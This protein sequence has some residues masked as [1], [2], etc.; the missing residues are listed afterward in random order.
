[1]ANNVALGFDLMYKSKTTP[2]ASVG[3]MPTGVYQRAKRD[4]LERFKEKFIITE[5]GCWQ[6]TACKTPDGYAQFWDGE[7][8]ILGHRWSYQYHAG[9]SIPDKLVIDHLCR[10]P[11]CVNPRHLEAVTMKENTDRGICYQVRAANAKKMTHCK[12]GHELF[13]DN[14]RIDS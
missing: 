3:I 6:W 7:G 4:P 9:S 5:S 10:N 14:L 13:G 1:M 8:H 2:F 11:S 12:R